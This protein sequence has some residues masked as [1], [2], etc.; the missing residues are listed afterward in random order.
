VNFLPHTPA[1]SQDNTKNQYALKAVSKQRVV[2][3]H[4]KKHIVSERNVM[5]QMN[6]PNLIRL[7]K[8]FS[9]EHMLYF[10]LEPSL[11]GELY[12]M[13]KAQTGPLPGQPEFYSASVVAAFDYLH[14]KSFIFRDLK[15][16][17]ILIDAEGYVPLPQSIIQHCTALTNLALSHT[18]P[19]FNTHNSRT[20]LC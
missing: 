14:N 3:T 9:D 13:L 5:M 7:C 16:E 11:G 10:L 1:P 20:V 4:Q 19:P 12:R 2:E 6:H 18:A 15:P 8:T 17:N